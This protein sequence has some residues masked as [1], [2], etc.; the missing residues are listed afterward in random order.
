M[1]ALTK[2]KVEVVF[3]PIGVEVVRLY[4]ASETDDEA[5]LALYGRLAPWLRQIRLFLTST[6]GDHSGAK[7]N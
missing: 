7:L 1:N 4:G 5:A 2:P 6:D 3:T